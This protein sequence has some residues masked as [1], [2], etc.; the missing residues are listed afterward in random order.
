MYVSQLALICT[1]WSGGTINML[2]DERA[3]K[4]VDLN[5]T[6]ILMQ[7]DYSHYNELCNHGNSSVAYQEELVE[8]T[9]A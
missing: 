3:T 7:I 2:V 1:L 4:I 6:E 9:L 5:Y 8:E